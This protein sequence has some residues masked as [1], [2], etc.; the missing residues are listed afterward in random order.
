MVFNSKVKAPMQFYSIVTKSIV[1]NTHQKIASISALKLV[2]NYLLLV[3]KQ[4]VVYYTMCMDAIHLRP[5]LEQT[6]FRKENQLKQ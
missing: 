4:F 2:T 5:N 3:I 6:D 1:A